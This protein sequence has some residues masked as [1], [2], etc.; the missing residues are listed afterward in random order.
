M[1]F[2]VTGITGFVGPHLAKVLLGNGHTV[3]GTYRNL[4]PSFQAPGIDDVDLLY[5]DLLDELSVK[6]LFGSHSFDGVFHIA[7]LTHPP[8]S[9]NNVEE[10][11]KCN[12]CGTVSICE[13]IIKSSGL[14]PKFMY[15]STSEVYGVVPEQTEITEGCPVN[16]INPYAVSKVCSEVYLRE[17]FRNNFLSGFVTRAFSKTGP[18][19]RRNYAISS[20]AYQ[21]ARIILGKQDPVIRIGNLKAKRVVMDI[22]DAVS[23]YYALMMKSI[24]NEIGN[25]EVFNICGD[26]MREIG[27]FLDKM[28]YI[29]RKHDN[30]SKIRLEKDEK[31]FRP[32]DIP[33]QNANSDKVRGLLGWRPL[34]PIEKT[35]ADLVNWWLDEI[36][37][38]GE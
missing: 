11:M 18:L 23:V 20:D 14:L 13:T 35:L 34:I 36:A 21:L 10:T 19:R 31:L 37:K 28:L 25:G 22:R 6:T 33:S 7:S 30:V 12:F 17:R 32:I 26:E 27:F 1:K 38:E 8:T 2:L 3:V 5:M 4:P 15:C 16:P 29:F 24:K 9:F